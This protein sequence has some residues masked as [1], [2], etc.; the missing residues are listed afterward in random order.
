MKFPNQPHLLRRVPNRSTSAQSASGTS[1]WWKL[2]LVFELRQMP[3]VSFAFQ[4]MLDIDV[5]Q[6]SLMKKKLKIPLSAFVCH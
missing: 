2:E 5:S 1:H 6:G 3:R 4:Y